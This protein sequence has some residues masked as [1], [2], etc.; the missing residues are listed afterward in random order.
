MISPAPFGGNVRTVVIKVDPELLRSHDLTADQIVEALRINNQTSPAGNVRIGDYNYFTPTNTTIK[1]V[2]DFEN[3]P[4]FK[5]GVANLYLRDVAKV[6]D[7]ADI[8][9]SYALVNGKRSIYLPVTKSADAST[10]EVVQNLKNALPKFQS[11]L[12][13]DVKLSYEFDHG[14]H[15]RCAAYGLDGAFISGR[16]AWRI[17][18]Y[19]DYS[20]F[21]YFRRVISF[22]VQSNY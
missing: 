21:Y 19:P 16:R 9:T 3:I 2:K 8:T 15:Y 1:T 20:G 22:A 12:P 4:L 5:G 7:A 10:W 11:V 14:R 6:E 17:D 18:R 13:E